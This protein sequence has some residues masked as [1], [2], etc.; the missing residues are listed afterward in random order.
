MTNKARTH[1]IYDTWLFQLIFSTEMF[2]LQSL[3]NNIIGL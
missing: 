3:T 1:K 2:F